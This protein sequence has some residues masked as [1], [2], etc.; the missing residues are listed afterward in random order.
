[1]LR[2][3]SLQDRH[4]RALIA[5]YIMAL[6]ELEEYKDWLAKSGKDVKRMNI[7]SAIARLSL[8]LDSRLADIRKED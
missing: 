2:I 1:M 5:G 4:D 6:E 8:R 7:E 3:R